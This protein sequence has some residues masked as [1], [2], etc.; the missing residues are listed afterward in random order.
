[1]EET[2]QDGLCPTCGG[3]L[4]R[5]KSNKNK[6]QWRR[7]PICYNRDHLKRWYAA[8]RDKA[9]AKAKEYYQQ[10]RK[11]RLEVARIN[12]EAL[13]PEER[14][15]ATRKAALKRKYGL[16]LEDYERMFT[17]QEGRCFLCQSPAPKGRPLSVDH[18]H[19]NDTVRK[20][21]C[22]VCNR[23]LGIIERDPEWVTRAVQYLNSHGG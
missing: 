13:S 6:G 10:T 2:N 8:N 7:C 18:C 22:E 15:L 20:L 23:A 1:M 3:Q 14:K 11:R 17:A 4:E 9:I 19:E 12:R 16:S 5:S 21:L